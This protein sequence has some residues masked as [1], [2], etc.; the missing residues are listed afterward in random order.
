[1]KY[2]KLQL[3]SAARGLLYEKD[4]DV[5]NAFGD[6]VRVVV[7]NATSTQGH[8]GRTAARLRQLGYSNVTAVDAAAYR[9]NTLIFFVAGR[10]PAHRRREGLVR[11]PH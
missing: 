2:V 3:T 9:G 4:V 6:F 1:M 10:R 8:A 5:R 11:P 7:A